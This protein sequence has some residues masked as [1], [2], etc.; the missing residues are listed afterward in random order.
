MV[1]LRYSRLSGWQ[2]FFLNKSLTLIK[3]KQNRDTEQA[4]VLA[5]NA[6]VV[7]IFGGMISGSHLETANQHGACWSNSLSVSSGLAQ[8][9]HLLSVA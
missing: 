2:D 4:A 6:V 5:G 1:A 8:A 9:L 7:F 3:D